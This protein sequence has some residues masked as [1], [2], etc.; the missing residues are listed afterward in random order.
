MKYA[1]AAHGSFQ[2]KSLGCKNPGFFYCAP[3]RAHALGGVS[4]KEKID[5][6]Q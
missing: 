6:G 4:G 2:F 5:A 3:G 1:D